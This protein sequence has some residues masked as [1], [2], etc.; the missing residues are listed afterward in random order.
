[1]GCQFKTAS[2]VGKRI[3]SVCKAGK[4]CSIELDLPKSGVV[5]NLPP[6]Q[7]VQSL[8]DIITVD[9]GEQ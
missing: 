2:S 8:R 1:L 3:L 4:E 7:T 5:D 6:V 9:G